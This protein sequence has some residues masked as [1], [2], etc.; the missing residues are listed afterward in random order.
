MKPV[1][2][3]QKVMVWV[4]ITILTGLFIYVAVV[5]LASLTH[6]AEAQDVAVLELVAEAKEGKIQ[7]YQ[8]R[9]CFMAVGYLH[10]YTIALDCD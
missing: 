10:G 6:A 4:L 3:L 5:K 9:G 2:F 8:Y 1:S 7:L